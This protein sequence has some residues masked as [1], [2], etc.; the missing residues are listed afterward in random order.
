[1]DV[2]RHHDVCMQLVPLK[3]TSPIEHGRLDYIRNLWHLH[4]QRSRPSMVQHA[5]HRHEYP[6]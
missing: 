1:M 6:A 2:I 4:P 5:I 3:P